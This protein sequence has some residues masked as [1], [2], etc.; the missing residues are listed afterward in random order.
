MKK[1]ALPVLLFLL[2]APALAQDTNAVVA[3]TLYA[4]GSTNT[5]TQADLVDAL[6][7]MN[8]KYHRDMDSEEGRRQ[9]HGRRLQ[10]Y[11]LTNATG[12]IY[13]A[14]IYE[15]GYV[16]ALAGRS[17]HAADPEAAAKAAEAAQ[18]AWEK[19]HLPPE[20]A[21]LRARQRAAGK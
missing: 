11:V 20:L 19:A 21:E 10:Q 3:A 4:D 17:P 15:D 12:R 18:A 14:S 16:H 13:R 1:L 2:A 8:R 9:W 7:L 6:G 5:W